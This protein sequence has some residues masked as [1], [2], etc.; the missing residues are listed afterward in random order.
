MV[1]VVFRLCV[2]LCIGGGGVC[3]LVIVWVGGCDLL[4]GMCVEW[5]YEG[6]SWR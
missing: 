5:I 4:N 1:L 2:V 6:V 3:S